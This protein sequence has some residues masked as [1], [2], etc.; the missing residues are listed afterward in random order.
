[1]LYILI[2]SVIDRRSCFFFSSIKTMMVMAPA[3]ILMLI[4]KS[5]NIWY[6]T[7]KI[8]M[9]TN[10]Q[11]HRASINEI[12]SLFVHFMGKYIRTINA[13]ILKQISNGLCHLLASFL[14]QLICCV[15]CYCVI[16]QSGPICFVAAGSWNESIIG[17]YGGEA[18]SSVR[19]RV[20]EKASQKIRA[21]GGVARKKRARAARGKTTTVIAFPTER[22]LGSS[23]KI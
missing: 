9:M 12:N 8:T 1:M 18:C 22:K 20:R 13:G 15:S 17:F 16:K 21:K 23:N 3:F 11:T 2:F 7:I 4:F 6:C 19:V 5:N 14:K 10:L